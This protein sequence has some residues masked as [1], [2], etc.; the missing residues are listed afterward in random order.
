MLSR[1]DKGEAEEELKWSDDEDEEETPEQLKSSEESKRDTS[2]EGKG[3]DRTITEQP[4]SVD[5]GSGGTVTPERVN[6]SAKWNFN[7]S[8]RVGRV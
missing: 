1:V 7:I 6:L 2:G 5:S 4:L 3:E 8:Y